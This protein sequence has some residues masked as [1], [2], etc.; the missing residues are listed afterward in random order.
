[1]FSRKVRNMPDRDA[2]LMRVYR[3]H[4]AIV[5]LHGRAIQA[6]HPKKA[7]PEFVDQYLKA[8]LHLG[9]AADAMKFIVDKLEPPK[10]KK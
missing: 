9:H 2:E 3:L 7:S 6:S 5:N 1:M 8:T 10:P 4:I